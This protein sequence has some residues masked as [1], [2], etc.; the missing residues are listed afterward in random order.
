MVQYYVLAQ[1]IQQLKKLH[2]VMRG[3]LLKTLAA[4]H[5]TTVMRMLTKYQTTTQTPAGK[6]LKCLQVRIER[7]DKPPLI[8]QFG[9][10]SLTHQARAILNDVPYVPYRRR[11]ELLT[12]LLADEC[13]L[14]G[15]Q[16][17]IEVHHIHKLADLRRNGRRAKPQWI[18]HMSA[19][20]RK[21][22]VVCRACHT[23]IHAGQPT[24]QRHPK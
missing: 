1:N 12:R 18:Q 20:Q 5:K 4:K 13:E 9:G 24:R 19:M 14:C 2:W 15:A 6:M 3:S 10:L 17:T 16:D 21:T 23:A 11:T 8:A 7:V 22:L